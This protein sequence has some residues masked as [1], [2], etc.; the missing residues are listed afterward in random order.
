MWR[1]KERNRQAAKLADQLRPRDDPMK[2][3]RI[4]PARPRPNSG[5]LVE[6]FFEALNQTT[7]PMSKHGFVQYMKIIAIRRPRTFLALLRQVL[8]DEARELA[9]R[10]G[11]RN[12]GR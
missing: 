10:T 11:T 6:A 9:R 5:Q 3:R 2:R 4:E 7:A 12:P 1:Q 8:E